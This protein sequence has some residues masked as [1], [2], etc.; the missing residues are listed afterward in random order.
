LGKSKSGKVASV[1]DG[2]SK[3]RDM[4]AEKIDAESK[5]LASRRE[6]EGKSIIERMEPLVSEFQAKRSCDTRD[7]GYVGPDRGLRKHA[8]GKFSEEDRAISDREEAD[9]GEYGNPSEDGERSSRY[10]FDVAAGRT[11]G[12]NH[13]QAYAMAHLAKLA[14]YSSRIAEIYPTYKGKSIDVELSHSVAVVAK[15]E[16]ELKKLPDLGSTEDRG[17]VVIDPRLKLM[18]SLSGYPEQARQAT[19]A[20]E[21]AHIGVRDRWDREFVD[22]SY[23]AKGLKSF[24][25]RPLLHDVKSLDRDMENALAEEY[26]FTRQRCMQ[27]D[28][29]RDANGPSR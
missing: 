24:R 3:Q 1:S 18:C 6:Y 25:E 2:A 11:P 27:L 26:K 4:T 20:L 13:D 17:L 29:E 10:R 23:L 14:G 19:K 12:T 8:E 5:R 22:M 7:L 21:D 28:N 9:T 16:E 15:R